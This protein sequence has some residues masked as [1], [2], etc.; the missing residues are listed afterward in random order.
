[1]MGFA[2]SRGSNTASLENLAGGLYDLLGDGDI[3]LGPSP[4]PDA[5]VRPDQNLLN[6]YGTFRKS[7]GS[8]ESVIEAKFTNSGLV[9]V[10]SGTLAFSGGFTQTAGATTV[11]GATIT[12]TSPLHILGGSIGGTGQIVADVWN[13]GGL[14]SPGFSPGTLTIDGDYTQGPDARLLLEIAGLQPGQFD[15]F[16]VT[17]TA[18]LHGFLEIS[19]LDGFQPLTGDAFPIFTYASLVG[20]F[21]SIFVMG[22][23]GYEFT[24][25]YGLDQL[26]LSFLTGNAPA[27]VP[28]PSSL[29][30]VAIGVVSLLSR[31][32][33][34]RTNAGQSM[35]RRLWSSA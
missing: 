19:L 24:P 15:V 30:L 4:R 6:N 29:F 13:E 7:G 2:D 14:V 18:T 10:Q 34:R 17:G 27:A 11:K 23:P 28:A 5:S 22:Q 26:N 35:H 31:S 8:A 25:T 33:R 16:N 32:R 12:S 1:M 3:L 9:D 21:D 20:Q